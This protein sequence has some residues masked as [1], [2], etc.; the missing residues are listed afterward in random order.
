MYYLRSEL[1]Y[2]RCPYYL[3]AIPNSSLPTAKREKGTAVHEN[4]LLYLECICREFW[5][6]NK[7]LCVLLSLATELY[8]G[9]TG[10]SEFNNID[11]RNI[12][13]SPADDTRCIKLIEFYPKGMILYIRPRQKECCTD[14]YRT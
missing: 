13:L 4:V 2:S 12:S 7:R 14:S 1:I 9:I 10:V 8:G 11:M 6:W 3:T 5:R